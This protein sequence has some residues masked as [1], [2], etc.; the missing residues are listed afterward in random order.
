MLEIL[1]GLIK[2]FWALIVEIKECYKTLRKF[3]VY[4]RYIKS[5]QS[6][7]GMNITI[8]IDETEIGKNNKHRGH[9]IKYFKFSYVER[10]GKEE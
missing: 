7:W 5:I 6:I 3:D 8:E 2:T 4:D 1:I 10:A 9:L